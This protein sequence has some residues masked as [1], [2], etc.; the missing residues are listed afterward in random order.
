MERIRPRRRPLSSLSLHNDFN[1]PLCTPIPNPHNIQLKKPKKSPPMHVRNNDL[2]HV[3]RSPHSKRSRI[4]KML[5]RRLWIRQ[6]RNNSC[7][8]SVS[9]LDQSFTKFLKSW[10]RKPIKLHSIDLN[11]PGF[12]NWI[13]GYKI[14]IFH[15][16]SIFHIHLLFQV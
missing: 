5:F 10:Q 8:N 9:N 2:H 7:H 1:N 15:Y 14:P 6:I 16:T 4:I 12:R 3:H 11:F 13:F